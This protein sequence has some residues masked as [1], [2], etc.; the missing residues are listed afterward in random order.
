MV[1]G[2]WTP[3]ILRLYLV[4]GALGCLALSG[5]HQTCAVVKMEKSCLRGSD[6]LSFGKEL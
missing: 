6:R 1:E 4:N 5:T 3:V 2:G